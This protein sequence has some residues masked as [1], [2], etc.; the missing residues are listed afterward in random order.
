METVP[1]PPAFEYQSHNAG[2]SSLLLSMMLTEENVVS[3]CEAEFPETGFWVFLPFTPS[4]SPHFLS[5]LF[6]THR[7][8]FLSSGKALFRFVH[9]N[10][11]SEQPVLTA[12]SDFLTL[13]TSSL[14]SLR[15]ERFGPSVPACSF[16]LN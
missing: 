2:L 8:H 11:E 3:K 15:H 6:V 5:L 10:D 1:A 13:G 9:S 12:T 7:K 14:P 16:G 4:V